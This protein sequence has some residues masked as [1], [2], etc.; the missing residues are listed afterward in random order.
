MSKSR[1][2]KA[3]SFSIGAIP[4]IDVLQ[5][6]IE[7]FGAWLSQ[8]SPG[9]IVRPPVTVRDDFDQERLAFVVHRHDVFVGIFGSPL[10]VLMKIGEPELTNAFYAHMRDRRMLYERRTADESSD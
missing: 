3:A 4:S 2:S 5:E 6:H 1:K 7:E 8:V 9:W 10:Q